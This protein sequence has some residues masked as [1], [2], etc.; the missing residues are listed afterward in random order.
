[1]SAGS[2]RSGDVPAG[3]GQPVERRGVDDTEVLI[4]GAGPGGRTLAIELGQRGVRCCLVER[5][6]DAGRLPKMER[7]NPRTMENYRR[8]GIA[9]EIRAAGL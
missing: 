7:C 4:V 3:T 1:M 8:L 2:E 5:R 6:P 9:D